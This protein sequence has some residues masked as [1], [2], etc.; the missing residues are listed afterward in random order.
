MLCAVLDDTGG[1]ARFSRI[2]GR[3][4]WATYRRLAHPF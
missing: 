4:R 1:A 3:K 2:F